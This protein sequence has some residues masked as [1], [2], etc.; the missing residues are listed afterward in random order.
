MRY[1][2]FTNRKN[3]RG[4]QRDK[5]VIS[6]S[7]KLVGDAKTNTDRQQDD[8]ISLLLFSFENEEVS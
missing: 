7:Q 1:R 6:Q 3:W 4:G 5:R 8:H 2:S